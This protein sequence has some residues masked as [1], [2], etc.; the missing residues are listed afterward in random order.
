MNPSEQCERVASALEELEGDAK[1]HHEKQTREK[2]KQKSFDKKEKKIL[3]TEEERQT[4]EGGGTKERDGS[5]HLSEVL[6]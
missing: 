1:K 6:N 4:R 5:T 3:D 2:R